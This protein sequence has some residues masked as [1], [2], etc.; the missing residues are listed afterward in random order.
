MKITFDLNFRFESN[1]WFAYK[2]KLKSH[3]K[4]NVLG[5][6]ALFVGHTVH[7]KRCQTIMLTS[8]YFYLRMLPSTQIRK[9]S[10]LKDL[11]KQNWT[12]ILVFRKHFHAH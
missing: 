2:G 11:T 5:W 7:I 10:A 6:R 4:S 3:L 12:K 8:T 9:L 1:T